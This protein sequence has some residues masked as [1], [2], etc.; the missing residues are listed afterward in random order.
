MLERYAVLLLMLTSASVHA[1]I[2][3]T[4]KTYDERL[5][6]GR[7]APLTSNLFGDQLN[8]KDGS[9]SFSQT[10]VSIPTNSG[11]RVEFV[12]TSPRQKQGVDAAQLPMGSGWEID[13]PYMMA[14]FDTRR[15]W[16]TSGNA[17]CSSSYLGPT[18][19]V[20]PSPDYNTTVMSGQMYWSGIHVNIPG[21]GFENVLRL[22]PGHPVPQDGA[23]YIGSA[24]GHWRIGCL[25]TIKNGV[26]EG[27]FVR[28]PDGTK[29]YFDWM[30]SRNA[31]DVLDRE[32]HRNSDGEGTDPTGTLVPTS[33]VFLYATKV[34]D[35]HGNTVL[36]SFDEVNKHQIKSI[37]SNDG[38][39]IDIHYNTQGQVSEV[40]AKGQV[41]KYSYDPFGNRRRLSE[42]LLPDQSKWKFSGAA[43]WWY[44][45]SPLLPGGFYTNTCAQDATGYRSQDPVDMSK[46]P[47][48]TFT[49]PSGATGTFVLRQLIHGSDNTPGGCDIFGSSMTSFWFGS[50]GVPSAYLAMSLV[51]K[52]ISGP[53]LPTMAWSY[54]YS[55]SWSFQ[56]DCSSGCRSK[57]TITD[58]EGV[59]T[60]Y[61]FGNSYT[62]DIGLLLQVKE[63]QGGQVKR[64]TT[65]TYSMS[66]QGYLGSYGEILTANQG[67][68]D[69]Y[70]NPQNY[71]LK[72]TTSVEIVQDASTFRRLESDFDLFAKPRRITRSATLGQ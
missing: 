1:Q 16:D 27:F 64:T 10:D 48:L 15:G 24:K 39:R 38:A 4:E 14:T 22:P 45:Q 54:S 18:Q 44:V 67:L 32:Y 61:T 36:F 56:R 57:T 17:R 30:A 26:G 8:I 62:S 59:A 35:R 47:T 58:P 28:I 52:S 23:T 25:P 37:Q 72:P 53:G 55:P 20:G 43:M 21:V 66:P 6:G 63:S 3:S 2:I 70:G 29:Y 60:E 41:W 40:H 65:H 71:I 50:Y 19:L 5:R 12:R 34:E 69:L 31:F 49:H 7:V 13:I 51:S 11:L 33:D 46:L 9:I 42:V 68:L